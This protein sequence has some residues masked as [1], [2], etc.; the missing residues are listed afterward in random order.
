MNFYEEKIKEIKKLIVS[1]KKDE[2]KTLVMA[3]LNMPYIPRKYESEFLLLRDSLISSEST[4]K[5]SL[6]TK[7]EVLTLLYSDDQISKLIAIKNMEHMNIRTF[8]T[9]VVKW[10]E[11][12]SINERLLVANL[13][14]LLVEQEI[15]VDIKIDRTLLNPVKTDDP[16]KSKFI[17]KTLKA[18]EKKEIKELLWKQHAKD[19]TMI[20][21]LN[22]FPKALEKEISNQMINIVAY[23][24]GEGNLTSEEKEIALKIGHIVK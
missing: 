24:F 12:A 14:E 9:Q 8:I 23:L 10:M 16:L 17:E 13:Y 4:S 2:A 19:Q 15:N 7:D 1:G 3:E 22:L 20:Y 21:A 18:I 11:S 5:E 6:M